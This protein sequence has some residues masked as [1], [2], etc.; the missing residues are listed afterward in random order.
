M[1]K[2]LLFFFI[3]ALGVSLAA[4]D[5]KKD[6]GGSSSV[7]NTPVKE[8]DYATYVGNYDIK[9]ISYTDNNKTVS[10]DDEK[11]VLDVGGQVIVGSA[12]ANGINFT[13]GLIQ[14]GG[15]YFMTEAMA[16]D[17]NTSVLKKIPAGAATG[18]VTSVESG[19]IL[20]VVYPIDGVDYNLTITKNSDVTDIDPKAWKETGVYYNSEN[21]EAPVEI[22]DA[23]RLIGSYYI[24]SMDI[25]CGSV[26]NMS[27]SNY[28][29]DM[30]GAK[31]IVGEL[32]TAVTLSEGAGVGLKIALKYQLNDN[33]TCNRTSLIPYEYNTIDD[34]IVLPKDYGKLDLNAIFKAEGLVVKGTETIEY[35]PQT[36][37][38]TTTEDGGVTY[39][40]TP[41]P[42][43]GVYLKITLK[44]SWDDGL[45]SG[46][47]KKDL[48]NTPYYN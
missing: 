43:N 8:G 25:R 19:N 35:Q 37:S 15:N 46:K 14:L 38:A 22:N 4:C 2:V 26:D 20:K 11:Q 39:S 28:K 16:S 34:T 29:Y 33:Y 3:A 30:S 6:D 31:N 27:V 1:R 24:Y 44:K 40:G 12:D 48:V 10:S 13:A 7:S 21:P 45:L 5:S 47:F 18:T 17:N 23:L 41:K 32:G 36:V 42:L 9:G